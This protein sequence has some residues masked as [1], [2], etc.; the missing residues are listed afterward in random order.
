MTS[1]KI[2]ILSQNKIAILD[3]NKNDLLNSD[4]KNCLSFKKHW[5]VCL[6]SHQDSSLFDNL[7]INDIGDFSDINGI[8][9]DDNH[10]NAT[11]SY[12]S[13]KSVK[14]KQ[15]LNKKARSR[16]KRKSNYLKYSNQTVNSSDVFFKHLI[17]S[18]FVLINCNFKNSVSY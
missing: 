6:K 5:S 9:Y 2:T 3:L 14:L 4:K 13:A 1:R 18:E 10:K 12:L 17:K 8:K 16:S 7:D 15:E 11:G